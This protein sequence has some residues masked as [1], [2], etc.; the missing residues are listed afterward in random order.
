M[1]VMEWYEIL[2]IDEIDSPAL[3]VFPERV[4]ANIENAIRIVGHANR[5]RPHVKTHKSP[6]VTQLMLQAGITK[7][8]CA[9]IAE[10]E[11]LA[12]LNAPDVL[13]A[14]Q[15]IGP[16]I[17][18]YLNL[19]KHYPKTSFSSLVDNEI[20]LDELSAKAASENIRCNVF[21]DIDLGMHRTGIEPNS[22]A[23]ILVESMHFKPS[24]QLIGFHGYDGHIRDN[25]LAIRKSNS[26][27][28]FFRMTEWINTI[29]LLHSVEIVC[30]G[31][32][33][34]TVHA[35][36]ENVTCSPGTFVYWDY[37]YSNIPDTGNFLQAAVLVS[38]VIS[39]NERNICLD[40]GHK[41]VAS[42]NMILNRIHILNL[43][44]LIPKSQSEEHLVLENTLNREVHLGDVIYGIPYHICPTVA[45][46][47][48][49]YIAENNRVVGEWS[50]LARSRKINF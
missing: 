27:D 14:Y 13:V 33:T 21:V 24:I 7:F 5:L 29:G 41:A 38:R 49:L 47:D 9:T 20:A 1:V 3:I 48:K 11:M 4:Q 18:R 31:S 15:L 46:Y 50:N 6:E 32:P 16:K 36:R 45:L 42:E 17:D 28:S 37:T 40:L 10:A 19:I 26:D 44:G 43:N 23:S 2:N 30:G 12:Q 35:Q 25:N 39:I 22:F 34:F 8:K